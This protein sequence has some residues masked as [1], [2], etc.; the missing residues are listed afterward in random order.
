MAFVGSQGRN[1]SDRTAIEW[2]EA[3]SVQFAVGVD[4]TA[5]HVVTDVE[6]RGSLS[7]GDA[8]EGVLNT[9]ASG[10]AS[11]EVFSRATSHAREQQANFNIQLGSLTGNPHALQMVGVGDLTNGF[12]FVNSW[13]LDTVEHTLK[14]MII[15]NG[16]EMCV[17]DWNGSRPKSWVAKNS[18]GTIHS[19]FP[20]ADVPT[21][22]RIEMR[23]PSQVIFSVQTAGTR[24]FTTLHT[25]S[26]STMASGML[27]SDRRLNLRVSCVAE[28]PS[29]RNVCLRVAAMQ[30]L[31]AGVAP[32]AVA[33]RPLGLFT[34][35]N[36]VN[37]NATPTLAFFAQCMRPRKDDAVA[38]AV[39]LRD[40]GVTLTK[41]TAM[42]AVLIFRNTEVA[43]LN[44]GRPSRP[45]RGR[46]GSNSDGD[47]DGDAM[48]L[49]TIAAAPRSLM[50]CLPSSSLRLAQTNRAPQK[51]TATLQ[52]GSGTKTLICGLLA[53]RIRQ[54]RFWIATVRWALRDAGGNATGGFDSES[55]TVL[56][57]C[58]P[59]DE[60]TKIR[61]APLS[62]IPQVGDSVMLHNGQTIATGTGRGGVQLSLGDRFIRLSEGDTLSVVV[63]G[64]NA[65][66]K[67]NMFVTVNWEEA[68]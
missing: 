68:M 4:H 44:V 30:L 26:A 57:V 39:T 23:W 62:R 49:P 51:L 15:V 59:S 33:S 45:H 24:T 52:A 54:P 1:N 60:T 65:G 55:T 9:G 25:V 37:V 31:H 11:I 17:T 8:G 21:Q 16:E 64:A 38:G 18:D 28:A 2:R 66:S 36:G 22:F 13:D 48:A 50:R 3:D 63:C 19:F 20:I 27:I 14:L 6:G 47:G 34:E 29:T 53:Y 58:Q 43:Q 5:V 56:A 61:V 35:L 41:A 42:C 10:P 46:R 12:H 67:N 40:V 7:V 32:S